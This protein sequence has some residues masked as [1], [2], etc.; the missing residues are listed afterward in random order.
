M[1]NTCVV[2]FQNVMNC[3]KYIIHTHSVQAK[4]T[5]ATKLWAS[6][7]KKLGD[8]FLSRVVNTYN[9]YI[10]DRCLKILSKREKLE[11][12]LI[13]CEK[14]IAEFAC[15]RST[16]AGTSVAG[17]LSEPKI[18]NEIDNS[19]QIEKELND[20]CIAHSTPIKRKKTGESDFDKAMSMARNKLFANDNAVEQGLKALKAVEVSY[21]NL[22]S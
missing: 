3:K 20:A 10:C 2:C 14:R 8:L 9:S 11:N 1:N 21:L 16:L 22:Y 7:P 17:T 13:S 18:P 12:D 4:T 15:G 19:Y 5:L 6:L